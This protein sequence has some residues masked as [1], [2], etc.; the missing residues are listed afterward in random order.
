VGVTAAAAVG[1]AAGLDALVGEP[2][3]RLH[4]VAWYGRAVGAVDRS[5]SRPRLVGVV[6]ATVLPAA[7]AAVVVA[8]VLAASSIGAGAAVAA[9]ALA[10]FLTASCRRLVTA[11]RTVVAAT[12][13]DPERAREAVPALVGRD[14]ASLSPAQLRSA[15]V[16]SAAENL[17]DG[18]VAPLSA[19]ALTT[20]LVSLALGGAGTLP[21]AAGAAAATW[22]KGVNT[23]D[24]MLG[25]HS[26]PVGWASARLDD[27]VMWVPAR[28]GAVLIALAALD[29][30]SLRAAREWADG[31][32]S[33]NSGW[34]MAA[35]AAVLDVR[36]E[37][38]G[39][40]VLNPDRDLPTVAEGQ[41]GVRVVAIAGVLAVLGTGVIVWF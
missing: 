22:V 11:A 32:P 38:P 23:L 12:E 30:G 6:A 9:A 4:P 28:L 36:L 27:A 35:L 14:P 24:S 10:L 8:V 40:Y 7:A 31:P 2:P 37:K 25:Y 41:R 39:V 13:S 21:L 17:A 33:P 20:A 34:P 1:V 3:T 16:E 18:L 15:A 26:K 29:P 19:F 5:W